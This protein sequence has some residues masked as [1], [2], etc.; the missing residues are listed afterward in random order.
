MKILVYGAG[1]VGG[2]L[3]A[4][5]FQQAH[6]VT[7][8]AR[9]VA[10]ELIGANGLTISEGDQHD[11][12][13]PTV[14]ASIMHAFNEGQQYDLIILAMKSYDLTASFD[15]LVAFCPDPKM[16]LT[17][18]NGIGIEQPLA[19]HFGAERV[20]AGSLTIPLRK[21]TTDHIVVEKEGRGLALAPTQ[22]KQNI[23]PWGALFQKA[24]IR[25]VLET[26]YQ[27]MKWSK[28]LLNM[29]GNATSAILNRKPGLVYQS[30]LM[31]NLEVKMLRE[32]LKVMRAKKIPVIDLPGSQAKRL[33]LGVQRMPK[34]FL[35]PIMANLVTEGRG[36]KMPSFQLDLT[37][38]KG[39]NEVIFHNGAVAQAGKELGIPTPVNAALNDILLKLAREELDWRAFDG[40]PKRLALEVK[41]Y[42]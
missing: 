1:A 40:R 8:V 19:Q 33:A 22:P 23:R 24:G 7:M 25:T 36:N 42:Q 10:A 18:Q 13:R 11:Q 38:G 34:L 5:L 6:E 12:V 30:D 9:E 14:L 21:E 2:Y 41:K 28:A 39:K 20:L 16:I 3:G 17:T 4:R 37:A 31:F 27:A 26:N 15:A 32:T 35:K 29:V